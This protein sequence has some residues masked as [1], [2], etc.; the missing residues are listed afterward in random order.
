MCPISKL[1][2]IYKGMK[3]ISILVTEN[4]FIV[5]RD[6]ILRQSQL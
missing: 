2:N 3:Q 6:I 5:N 1:G 4:F